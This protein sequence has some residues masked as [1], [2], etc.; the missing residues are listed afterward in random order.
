MLSPDT[1]NQ[2]LSVADLT[3][4][5]KRLLERQFTQV[6]VEGEISNMTLARSGHW[7]FTLKDSQAQL[8]C[9][10]FKGQNARLGR[11]P[12]EGAQ[13]LVSGRINVYEPRGGYQLVAATLEDRGAGLLRERFEQL[14]RTLSEEGLFDEARKRPLPLLPHRIALVTSPEGA[15]VRDMI[16]VILRR[17]PRAAI[18]ICP[19]LVQGEAAPAQIVAAIER[20]QRLAGVEVLIVGRGGGSIEDLWAFNDEGVARAIAACKIPV[21]SAVGHEVDVTIADFVADVRAATPSVAGEL[22]VPVLGDLLRTLARQNGR[23]SR[24]LRHRLTDARLELKERVARL[25]QPEARL[26]DQRL[27]LDQSARRLSIALSRRVRGEQRRLDAKS[28]RLARLHPGRRVALGRLNLAHLENRLAALAERASRLARDRLETLKQRLAIAALDR[29]REARQALAMRSVRLNAISPLA[30]LARGYSLVVRDNGLL[31][32]D[33]G[34]VGVGDQV[35]IYPQHGE[36][37]AT[38]SARRKTVRKKSE[39]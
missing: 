34:D 22:V 20:A 16:R 36:I 5:I 15:A 3:R 18:V 27:R 37:R 39:S 7:Y 21:I 38:I 24:A 35:T 30:V 28:E 4:D 29:R 23:L 17:F 9:V 26:A 14:K 31:V 19:T 1:Q 8:S 2:V 13:V 11:A 25:P 6:W 32:R 10:M 12:K 33:A